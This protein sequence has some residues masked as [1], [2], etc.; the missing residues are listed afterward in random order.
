MSATQ[1]TLTFPSFLAPTGQ[2]VVHTHTTAKVPG[3]SVNLVIVAQEF[4]YNLTTLLTWWF[5]TLQGVI[6]SML[7]SASLHVITL[8]FNRG[9]GP[10]L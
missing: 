8:W 7:W 6:R 2:P 10:K 1:Q 3:I 4:P 5:K 9:I